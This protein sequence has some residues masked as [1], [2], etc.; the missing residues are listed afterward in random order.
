ME[1]PV[2]NVNCGHSYSRAAI[3]AHI[4]NNRNRVQGTHC[5]VAGCAHN[6]SR[7]TLEDDPVLAFK[8]RRAHKD[9]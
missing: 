3:E 7:D 2:K 8:I 9:E 4:R 6:V 5:P 1:E